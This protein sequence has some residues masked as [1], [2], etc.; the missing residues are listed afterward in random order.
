MQQPILHMKVYVHV[1][2]S[3]RRNSLAQATLVISKCNDTYSLQAQFNPTRARVELNQMF[4][5]DRATCS[6]PF[7]CNIQ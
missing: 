7:F 3:L 4:V 2:A 1:R 6:L 5:Q